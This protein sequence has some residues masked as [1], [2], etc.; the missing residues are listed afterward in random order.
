ML[1]SEHT[2]LEY[3]CDGE[4]VKTSGC[5]CFKRFWW[6]DPGI[7][8]SYDAMPVPGKYRSGCSQSSIRLNTGTPVKKVEKAAK[9]L[10]GPATLWVEQEYELTS[11]PRACVSSC[12]CNRK[13]PSGP[14]L[15]REAPWSSK[16]YMPYY[17]GM[18]GPRSG[19]GW[20]REQGRG[21]GRV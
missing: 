14:L 19:S 13:W 18:P 20:V 17:R 21:G 16:L 10:K 12:I 9:E 3:D 1:L 4:P 7:A 11:T 8:V 6:R 15:G 2:R 5:I